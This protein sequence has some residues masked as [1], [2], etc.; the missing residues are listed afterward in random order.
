MESQNKAAY[1]GHQGK[2]THFHRDD[3]TELGTVERKGSLIKNLALCK[4]R[5]QVKPAFVNRCPKLT[6]ESEENCYDNQRI[7]LLPSERQKPRAP[8]NSLGI[9]HALVHPS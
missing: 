7:R 3:R 1:F 2:N 8:S 4:G 6:H 5:H 9:T